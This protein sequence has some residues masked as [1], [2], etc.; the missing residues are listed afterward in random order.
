MTSPPPAHQP[1]FKGTLGRIAREGVAV[2]FFGCVHW[3]VVWVLHQTGE[4]SLWWARALINGTAAFAV[5]LILAAGGME[6]LIALGI[7][8]K[9]ELRVDTERW[10]NY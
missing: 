4:E 5:A 6:L 8:L 1:T 10:K 3:L 7:D 2:V 9:V